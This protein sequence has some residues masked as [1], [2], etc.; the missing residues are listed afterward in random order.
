MSG[1]KINIVTQTISSTTTY[2]NKISIAVLNTHATDSLRVQQE[3]GTYIVLPTGSSVSYNAE[4]GSVL[5]D[6]TILTDASGLEAQ[7]VAV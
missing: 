2:S 1:I 4:S 5:P 6:I 3:N 7:I